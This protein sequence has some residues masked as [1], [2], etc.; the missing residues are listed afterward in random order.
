ITTADAQHADDIGFLRKRLVV[1]TLERGLDVLGVTT[2]TSKLL[3][4]LS[5]KT[6]MRVLHVI[7]GVVGQ[8]I[9]NRRTQPRAMFGS[10]KQSRCIEIFPVRTEQIVLFLNQVIRDTCREVIRDRQAE[11]DG[12]T[13]LLDVVV[14]VYAVCTTEDVK[15]GREAVT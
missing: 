2:Q 15:A 7:D 10:L 12:T 6:V 3:R 13:G 4:E 8:R 11:T 1:V 5:I 14:V 9:A